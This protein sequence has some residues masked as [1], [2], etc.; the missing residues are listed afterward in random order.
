MKRRL[1]LLLALPK[2]T[3]LRFITYLPGEL[4]FSLRRRYWK[5]RLKKMGENVRIDTGVF[6][7]NPQYITIEDNSW[8]DKNVHI[9]AGPDK[10]SR[11]RQ[12]MPNPNFKLNKGEVFIGKNIH[13]APFCI[14]SGIGGVYISDN[15]GISAYAKLYSFSNYYRDRRDSAN[16]EYYFSCAA[17]PVK[18][19][20]LEGPIFIAEN[21]GIGLN[22]TIMPG[23]S[24]LK[25]SFITINSVVMRS[26]KENT[27]IGGNPAHKMGNRFE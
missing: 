22:V 1:K 19:Y 17:D 26:F 3:W 21:V 5:S 8:I 12:F 27:L 10:S 15:C 7:Q 6:F 18:Q 24:I 25:N 2:N 11:Q 14:I 20:M 13:I 4:A 16:P 23:V 9:L